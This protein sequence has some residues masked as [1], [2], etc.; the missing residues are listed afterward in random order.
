MQSHD[1][2]IDEEDGDGED[3]AKNSANPKESNELKDE[4]K[5]KVIELKDEHNV[6]V[7]KK[8]RRKNVESRDAWTQTD[9]SDYMLIKQRQQEKQKQLVK[10]LAE[11]SQGS[12]LR[13]NEKD[14]LNPS[15]ELTIQ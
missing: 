12:G 15:S 14:G 2:K 4:E 1:G 3:D 10:L 8:R 6:T 11:K 9:R 7:H 13:A 5:D